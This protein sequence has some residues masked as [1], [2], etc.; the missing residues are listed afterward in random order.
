MSVGYQNLLTITWNRF[1]A[2]RRGRRSGRMLYLGSRAET[3]DGRGGRIGIPLSDR[4]EHLGILGKTGT[5]KT[6]LLRYLC[7]QDIAAGHGFAF[8]DLHGDTTPFL[9]GLIGDEEKRRRTGLSS[10]TI[11]SDPSD[12]ERS[13][14]SNMLEALDEQD[15]FVEIAE[16]VQILKHRWKLDALGARTDEL[17]RNTLYVLVSNGLTFLEISPLLT[18]DSFRAR[19]LG[20]TPMGEARRYFADRFDRLSP[21]NQAVYREAIL[22]K[23]SL[24]M[25][26]PHFRHLLGQRRSTID[27]KQAVDSGAFVLLNLEKGRLGEEGATL[28][29]L[30]LAKLKHAILARRTRRLFTLYC[31]ALQPL[32]AY[33]AGIAVRLSEARKFGVSVVSAN[34]YLDQYSPAM[35]AAVLAMGSHAFLQLSGLD[36]SRVSYWSGRGEQMAEHLRTLPR[37]HAVVR[38][39]GRELCEAVVPEIRHPATIPLE[40][41]RRVRGRCTSD[42]AAIEREILERSASAVD[43]REGLGPEYT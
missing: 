24:Y 3:D 15:A 29:A 7:R 26:D 32:V 17:L 39:R 25:A 12:R 34:Q 30:L 6:S 33:D 22:N 31:D 42:R 35:R 36:A 27:L 18:S 41:T 13:V 14:G 8:F 28:A 11:L 37:R 38:I 1:S 10:R 2:W 9:L 20:R 40:L 5:G 16:T 19:C 43:G 4:T 21:Q 23:V